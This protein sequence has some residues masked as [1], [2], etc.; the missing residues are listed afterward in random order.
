MLHPL[1]ADLVG[2]RDAPDTLGIPWGRLKRP[3]R[4]FGTGATQF[5]SASHACW[6]LWLCQ[7]SS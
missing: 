6:I 2:A 1:T 4:C 5:L 7:V 3:G